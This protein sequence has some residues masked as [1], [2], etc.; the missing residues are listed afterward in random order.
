M[1]RLFLISVILTL[2]LCALAVSVSASDRTTVDYTDSDGVKH[3]VPVV[4]FEN[5]TPQNVASVLG[6]NATQQSYFVDDGAYVVLM[7][8]DGSLCAYPTWYTIE[9]SGTSS[10]YVAISEVEYTYINKMEAEVNGES[11]KTFERGAMRYVEFPEGMTHLRNNGVFG[12]GT[13]YENN[14]IEIAIPSTVVEIQAGA[15]S[16]NKTLK[17]VR[18]ADINNLEKI[19]D[20]AFLD[21]HALE[22]FEFE[23]LTRLTYIDGFNYCSL[24]TGTLDLS[25]SPLVEIG[26]NAF[27]G[28]KFTSVMLPDSVKY[29]RDG[30]FNNNGLKSFKFPA[31]LEYIGTDTLSSNPD[32][33][34]ESGIL[35][36]GLT[37]VGWN[38][39]N[40]CKMLPE[41]IVFPEGVTQI[42][43]EGFPNV[44]RPNKQGRLNLVFLGKMTKV[45]IDGSAYQD[46]AE[47]VVVYFAQNTISD[48]N[49]YVYSF[50]DKESGALGTSVS[51]SGT[52]TL[53]VS[54]KSVSSTSSVGNNFIQLIF[55]GNNGTVEQ[56]Y[57]LTVNGNSITEDRG[58]F[59]FEN[60]SCQIYYADYTDCT[61]DKICF[62]CEKNLANEAHAFKEVMVYENGF[63]APGV[64]SE[65]CQNPNCT[66]SNDGMILEPIFTSLGISVSEEP[67]TNGIYSVVQGYEIN[68][69]AYKDYVN[70]GNTLSFG[71]VIAV[72]RVT[73]NTPLAAENG[74]VVAVNAEKTIIVPQ[75][76]VVHNYVDLKVVG[77]SAANNGEE[78]IMC[79][80]VYD[81]SEIN[82]VDNGAQSATAGSYTVN[83]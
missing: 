26:N 59:D 81:G 46:W 56:S 82:Y 67:D 80:F 34:L 41:T 74:E 49:G 77:L 31:S 20:D 68:K 4:K 40:G 8:K 62:V 48:F 42:P 2:L 16:Q 38:F 3:S 33:V 39:L 13:H 79:M 35:P 69:G 83:F 17:R 28:C 58:T 54:D 72:K 22:Y 25:A 1:K 44:S 36:S 43:D 47:Q 37:Y 9:P 5:D 10:T 73:G 32:M 27:N 50:T 6:N 24:L 23:K 51:Q 21:C 15:F 18:I 63:M 7:A 75:S 78:I 55:C 60:H 45:I 14:V 52:L 61:S 19:S 71:F 11:A 12:R 76:G 57:V 65:A 30:V 29:L 64:K 66:V 70:S 53:D